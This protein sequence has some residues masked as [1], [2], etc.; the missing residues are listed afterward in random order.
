[1]GFLSLKNSR[2]EG[3]LAEATFFCKN[4]SQEKFNPFLETSFV[5]EIDGFDIENRW[6]V[7]KGVLFARKMAFVGKTVS[8][9]FFARGKNAWKYFVHLEFGNLFERV[10]LATRKKRELEGFFAPTH[11][12]AKW[13]EHWVFNKT[14][15]QEGNG[16]AK[17]KKW[18]NDFP[19]LSFCQRAWP[20]GLEKNV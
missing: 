20:N 9:I 16:S 17:K 1:M 7:Q 14:L 19:K 6:V 5:I 8:K 15:R 11:R 18:P 12:N 3:K 4:I 2:R 13:L 10:F